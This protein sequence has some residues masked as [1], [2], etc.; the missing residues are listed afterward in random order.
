MKLQTFTYY[1]N[2]K[3]KKINVKVCKTIWNKFWGLMFCTRS[4]SLLFVFN[5][6][7]RLSI[8]SFFCKPFT[9]IWLDEGKRVVRQEEVNNWRFNISGRGKYILEIPTRITK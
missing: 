4:P 1:E 7:K 3:K 2:G 6:E 5:K 9:A 8:H